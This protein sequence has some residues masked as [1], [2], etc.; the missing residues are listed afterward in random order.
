[1]SMIKTLTGIKPTGTPHLGNYA[2]AIRPAIEESRRDDIKSYYFLADLH[3]IIGVWDPEALQDST[4]Q[5]AASWLALGLDT[6]RST[7]LPSVRHS[8]NS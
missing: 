4:R 2:G 1:M 6:D 8:R 7:F 5:V 3:T